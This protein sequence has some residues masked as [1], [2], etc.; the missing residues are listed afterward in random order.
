VKNNDSL[1]KMEKLI[2]QEFDRLVSL[3]GVEPKSAELYFNIFRL[4]FISGAMI[5]SDLYVGKRVVVN[6][7][8]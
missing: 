1:S 2:S 5:A 7:S 8:Q 4:G 3:D 6:E